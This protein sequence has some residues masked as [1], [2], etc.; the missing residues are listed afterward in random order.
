MNTPSTLSPASTETPS[1][2]QHGLLARTAVLAYG[3]T[4][5]AIGV[6]G[7]CWL[8]GGS[9][10]LIPFTGGPV[11]LGSVEARVAFNLAFVALFGLQHAI[12]A[13]PAFKARWTR[14]VPP[15]IERSTFV[16]VTGLLVSGFMWLWQPLP[17]VVWSVEQPLVAGFLF[18]LGALGWA[19]LFTASFAIDHFE[20][21]GLKQV[22]NAF[23]GG[24]ARPHRIVSRLMYRFDRHPLMSGMLFGLWCTP[25][26]RV[27]H[28]VLAAG[29]TTYIVLG[30]LIEE[31]TL[32]AIHGE[33]YRSYRR[34]VPALVPFP[35]RRG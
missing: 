33:E 12:M 8:I 21:F 24:E 4:A 11:S 25:L 10:G 5:Y 15:A 19:Y 35:G 18:A 1:E 34:R 22:W 6:A 31:R 2:D 20:L 3:V 9:L 26:M 17:E 16:L 23:R 13:R 32:V 7:L 29:L 28:L 27:D 14:V 30:V